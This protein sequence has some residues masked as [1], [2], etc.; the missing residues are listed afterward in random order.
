MC[1]RDSVSGLEIMKIFNLSPGK[2]VGVIKSLVEEAIL[3][4][5]IENSYEEAIKFLNMLKKTGKF[6]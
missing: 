1:I 4:G 5:E 6:T 3:D 2:Q